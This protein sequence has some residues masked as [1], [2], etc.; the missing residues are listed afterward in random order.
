MPYEYYIVCEQAGGNILWIH[1]FPVR[2]INHISTQIPVAQVGVLPLS[3]Q[4]VLLL[5]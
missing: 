2:D 5:A 1:F 3:L 4:T